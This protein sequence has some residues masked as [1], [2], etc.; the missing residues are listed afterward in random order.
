M[1]G[2]SLEGHSESL[3]PKG[4]TGVKQMKNNVVGLLG[5]QVNR[6]LVSERGA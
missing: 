2:A 6:I 1:G 5:Y 4:C 3:F